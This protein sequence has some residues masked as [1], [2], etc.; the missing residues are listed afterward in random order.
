MKLALFGWAVLVTAVLLLLSLPVLAG[1]YLEIVP[2]LNLAN[3]W[4]LW[5]YTTQSAGNL[6][7]FDFLGFFRGYTLEIIYCIGFSVSLKKV[8]CIWNMQ[9]T[10]GLRHYTD[11]TLSIKGSNT[12]FAYYITGLI[13][14]D[15]T[16]HVPKSERSCKDKINYPSIQIVFHLKDLPLALLIQR[17]VRHG[18]ISKKKGLNT[19]I[20]TVDNIEGVIFLIN[21][22]NGKMKTN[23]NFALHR[24]IDWYNQYRGTSIEKK[25]LNTNHILSNPW[26]SGFIESNGHFSI[27]S[28]ESGKD[29]K[30]ECKFELSQ[31]QKYGNKDNLFFLEEI[32]IS[33]N[34][35]VKPI[36]ID[37][38]N[39]QYRIRTTNLKAN[40]A[41]VD[42]LTKYPLFGTKFLDFNDWAKVVNVFASVKKGS[43]NPKDNMENI[44]QIKSNMNDKRTI[45]VWDHLQN[46]YNLNN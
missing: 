37:T 43:F 14:G 13:E 7:R 17:E 40:L 45:F 5:L 19:Y 22:L 26:L 34:S 27:R 15:G 31:R 32:A 6:S 23:K 42:Y 24:L 16:I 39:P 18:S 21:L 30:I 33:I 12:K 20:Y 9:N 35:N 41:V 10:L 36:R 25:G 2:A 46:F 44:K 11:K 38:N 28:T 29:P 1:K 3:C 4:K 8:L